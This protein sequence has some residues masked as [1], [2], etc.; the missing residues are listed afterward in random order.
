ME[1]L[2]INLRNYV[3][4][5][6]ANDDELFSQC[7]PN[8]QAADFLTEQVPLLECPDKHLEEI[9]YFRWW[10]FRKH[11]KST[12]VGH[13][14]TEFLPPVKWAGAYNSIVCPVC[15]H[16]RE[17]GWLRDEQGWVKECMDFWLSEQGDTL[18]YSS[19]LASAVWDYCVAKNDYA[20]GMEKLPQLVALF[21]KREKLQKKACGLYWS[22]DGRDGM[23]YSISGSGL[24]PTLNAYVRADALAIS[25]LAAMTGEDA[26]ADRFRK[27]AE[28]LREK[29]D[30][31][32]WDQD[33]YRVLPLEQDEEFAEN[34]RP[35]ISPERDVK[36]LLG[37]VPWYFEAP[38]PEQAQVFRELT[39]EEGFSA[40]CGLTTAE[41]RHPRFLEEHSHECLWNGPVWPFATSQTLVAVANMLRN[42]EQSVLTGADYYDMLKVYA[43]SHIITLPSGRKVPWIDENLDPFT[44]E[45]L[46]RKHLE[47]GGWQ[48]KKGGYERGKDYNHSLFCDLV[49]SGLLGIRTEGDRITAQPLIPESWDYFRVENLYLQGKRWQ[50]I[51]DR[52]G[53][54]YRMGTG[55]QVRCVE[56]GA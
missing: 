3:S 42:T 13:I 17:G 25:R 5:F 4:K 28:E 1:D 49:L 47:K 11:F 51:Y 56:E 54:K 20:Y 14:I 32:L 37:Y 23:E 55:L 48:E 45:W 19:W 53:E 15:F 44:G 34:T 50:V 18:K 46:A 40:P 29:M 39:D 35:Q 31:L 52:T 26:L 9:Y 27:I 16:I 2:K 12:P 36:E 7:I 33:F 21:E 38:T 41:R 43:A 8:A 22:K 24:R 10:T 6:N 30:T